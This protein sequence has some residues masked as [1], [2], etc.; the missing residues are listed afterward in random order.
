MDRTVEC[1]KT[2]LGHVGEH[3]AYCLA[4]TIEYDLAYTVDYIRLIFG[5]T[6]SEK[7]NTS[8]ST[9]YYYIPQ[10]VMGS[11]LILFQIA[12]Y[13]S[14]AGGITIVW[15]SDVVVF[16]LKRSLP[17]SSQIAQDVKEHD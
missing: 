7:I 5:N 12:G 15:K 2:T 11:P 4:I 3:R 14:G 10:W 6:Y 9:I 17:A 16:T 1:S 13:K 8:T